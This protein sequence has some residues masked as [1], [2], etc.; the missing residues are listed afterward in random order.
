LEAGRHPTEADALEDLE[1][2]R[3]DE[4]PDDEQYGC[5]QNDGQKHERLQSVS[6]IR[7]SRGWL[8]KRDPSTVSCFV[9]RMLNIM[10]FFLKVNQS[11][12]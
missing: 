3:E 12:G 11:K 6:Y 2:E 5:R 1:S 10:Q 9:K 7:V 8:Q 4:E